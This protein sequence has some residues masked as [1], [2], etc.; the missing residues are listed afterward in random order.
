MCIGSILG[1]WGL[2][3]KVKIMFFDFKLHNFKKK[4]GGRADLFWGGAGVYPPAAPVPSCAH[5]W[6]APGKLDDTCSY[7]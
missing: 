4:L 5:V 7:V 2:A 3:G 6:F 1:D